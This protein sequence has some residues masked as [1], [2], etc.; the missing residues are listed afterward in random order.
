[1]PTLRFPLVDIVKTVRIPR[2]TL[3]GAASIFNQKDTH[4][5]ITI[6]TEGANT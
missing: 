6:N 2:E 4:D 5:N 1:M 3:A